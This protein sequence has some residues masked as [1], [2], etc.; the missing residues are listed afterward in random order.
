[1]SCRYRRSGFSLVELLI[2]RA[3]LGA[4]VALVTAVDQPVV[5]DQRRKLLETNLAAMRR[6]IFQFYNDHR[7][8]PY[9]GQDPF[10]N[11]VSFLDTDKS[12]LTQGVRLGR[13]SFP[14]RRHQYLLEIPRDPTAELEKTPAEHWLPTLVGAPPKVASDPPQQVS[15]VR[16]RTPGYENL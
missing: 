2:A 10:G 6:A 8:Y 3:I 15:D 11:D 5:A 16:S 4:I 9:F 1:M 13:G 12:E 14:T 7:R